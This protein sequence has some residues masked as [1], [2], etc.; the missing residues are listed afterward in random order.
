LSFLS[1]IFGPRLVRAEYRPL[2]E[3][4]VRLGRD[5]SWYDRGGVPDTIDGRFDMIAAILALVLLRIEREGAAGSQAS[6]LVTEL[7]IEDMEGSVR[8]IGIG[9][10]MV[11]K[12]VGAMMGAL[13]GRLAAFRAAIQAGAG[14]E[15]A[16]RRN[17]FH[18]AA[19]SDDAAAFVS[20]RLERFRDGL[21]AQSAET[22][23]S[24]E[25]PKP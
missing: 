25:V 13:G 1:R 4:V 5:P 17:I 19:P 6:A 15:A 16:V 14:F 2:Y 24:G 18:D 22:L 12:Q 11:G 9:D 20:A 8:Q 21:A 23:L 7:F 10:L 3:G